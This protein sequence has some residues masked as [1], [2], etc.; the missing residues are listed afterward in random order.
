MDSKVVN[1]QI[2]KLIWPALREAGFTTFTARCAWRHSEDKIDVVEFQSFN[3]YNADV[4]GV[5]TFSFAVRLGTMHLYV[6]PTWPPK[7]KDGVQLPSEAE[8]YFRSSLERSIES[9]LKDKTIWPVDAAGRNLPWCIKGVLNLLPHAF[10]WFERLGQ[11]SEVLRI[12]E[13]EDHS[14]PELWG[15]GGNPSPIRSYLAGYVALALGKTE[16]AQRRL[17]EAVDSKCFVSL[18]SSAQGAVQRAAS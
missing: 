7:A 17:Q 15:F 11:R 8:C 10:A 13:E 18:F 9:M 12:L 16:L 14:M 1:R 5:T 2:K 6:P 3:K 4:L